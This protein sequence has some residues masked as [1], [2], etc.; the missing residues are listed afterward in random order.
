MIDNKNNSVIFRDV[1]ADDVLNF[2]HLGTIEKYLNTI[3]LEEL[4]HGFIVGDAR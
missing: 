4:S 2:S 3:E 1:E